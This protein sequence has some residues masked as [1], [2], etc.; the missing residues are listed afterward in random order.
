[1]TIRMI[2][3]MLTT[4]LLSRSAATRGKRL[5]DETGYA[6]TGTTSVFAILSGRYCSSRSQS[7]Q[8]IPRKIG[9]VAMIFPR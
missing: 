4:Y 9:I 6:E 1:M 5:S 8:E 7:I 3:R 2:H